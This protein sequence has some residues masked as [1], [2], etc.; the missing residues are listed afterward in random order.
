MKSLIFTVLIMTVFSVE[1]K[2]TLSELTFRDHHNL[3]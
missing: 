3:D 1:L 2:V